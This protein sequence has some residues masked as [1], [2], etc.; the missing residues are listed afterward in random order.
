[1]KT[2]EL[3]CKQTW[4]ENGQLESEQYWLN[5]ERHNE[6]GP[7]YRSWHES[8]ENMSEQYWLNDSLLSKNEW[9]QQVNLTSLQVIIDGAT[10][11]LERV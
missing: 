5:G 1:M 2:Q 7:A 3:I 9:L 4:H 8:G 11:R 6:A 10:Y